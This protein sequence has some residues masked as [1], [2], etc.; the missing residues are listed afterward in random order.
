MALVHTLPSSVNSGYVFN[1]ARTPAEGFLAGEPNKYI[2]G[3]RR[4]VPP[5]AFCI[6]PIG[7]ATAFPCD[8]HAATL[9]ALLRGVCTYVDA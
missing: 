2:G 6:L 1:W 8:L 9:E 3:D 7:S 4:R 5:A